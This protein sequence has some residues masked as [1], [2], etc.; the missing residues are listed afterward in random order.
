MVHPLG[1]QSL[2]RAAQWFCKGRVDHCWSPGADTTV[3]GWARWPPTADSGVTG[4]AARAAGS[5]GWQGCW[6]ACAPSAHLG[7]AGANW[8]PRARYRGLR[9]C[10]GYAPVDAPPTGY[11]RGWA[12]GDPAG[13]RG[14]SGCSWTRLEELG[15]LLL[16][17]T[18]NSP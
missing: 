15:A 12:D 11:W 2:H 16:H 18:G 8:G 4:W 1:C 14:G 5:A 13:P 6:E 10:C 3:T 7:F 9:G 17:V